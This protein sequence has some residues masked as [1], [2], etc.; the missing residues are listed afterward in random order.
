MNHRTV[1]RGLL[2]SVAAL[3]S[4]AGAGAQTGRFDMLW[5]AFGPSE[6]QVSTTAAPQIQRGRVIVLYNWQAGLYPKQWEGQLVNGGVPVSVDM[7]VHLNKLRNDL[8]LYIPPSFDG[9]AVIDYEDWDCLWMDTPNLYKE[10][11]RAVTRAR[12]AGI[13][14]AQVEEYSKRDHEAAAK[15]F[16]LQTINLCKQL[17]PNAKWG[18]YGYP[19]EHHIDYRQQM[20]WLWDAS[21]ALYPAAYVVYPASSASPTP[22]GYASMDYYPAL[23][24]QLVGTSR[25]LAGTKPVVPFV[26]S[27]YHDLNPLFRF[28]FLNN[29]DLTR[30]LREPRL[31]GADGVIFWDYIPDSTLAQ[32][33]TQFIQTTL[34]QIVSSVDLEFNPPANQQSGG[35]RPD[36]GRN[37]STPPPPPP[38][39]PP[40][41]PPVANNNSN[42]PGGGVGSYTNTSI[43]SSN[44]NTATGTPVTNGDGETAPTPPADQQ[45]SNDQN[46]PA[47]QPAAGSTTKPKKEKK[48]KTR[49]NTKLADAKNK[50]VKQ[51]DLDRLAAAA[52]RQ[53]LMAQRQQQQQ[54]RNSQLADVPTND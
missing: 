37:G 20:Q 25:Q 32:N 31:K 13:T 29:L 4:C 33:Y 17:R 51:R 16:F 36:D 15:D 35:N 48:V 14:E 30:M 34:S 47:E 26:W 7:T 21:T 38:V 19:R 22:F 42:P 18:Y 54:Q 44:T 9:Y 49:T 11:T 23:M 45:A 6:N 2:T 52:R 46:P 5:G 41:A 8:D 12:Y 10:L 39:T 24:Q 43:P 50:R 40:P 53:Q 1:F 3:V 27:R 28:Q